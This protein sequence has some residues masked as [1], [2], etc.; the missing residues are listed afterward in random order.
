MTSHIMKCIPIRLDPGRNVSLKRC[1]AS[2]RISDEKKSKQKKTIKPNC[3]R[4]LVDLRLKLTGS[5]KYLD[6]TVSEKREAID[7]NH[8]EISVIRQC[9]L[10]G[11]S[12]S[13]YYY[14]PQEINTRNL[15]IMHLIDKEFTDHPSLVPGA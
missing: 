1:Q 3:L 6:L 11:L 10:L 2:F 7:R 8:R 9:E 12:R 14:K 13:A 5:K 4:K 15:D